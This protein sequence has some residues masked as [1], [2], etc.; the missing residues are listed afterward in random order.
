MITPILDNEKHLFFNVK[1]SFYDTERNLIS[2]DDFKKRLSNNELVGV[3]KTEIKLLYNDDK[4]KLRLVIFNQYK[5]F[6]KVKNLNRVVPKKYKS[7]V[8]FTINL[9]T[10][11]IYTY[12]INH[13]MKNRTASKTIRCNVFYT[14]TQTRL[15][16]LLGHY[17]TYH[18]E[19]VPLL[20]KLLNLKVDDYITG[21]DLLS[22]YYL[23]NKNIKYDYVDNLK[24]FIGLLRSSKKNYSNKHMYAI[25][26]EILNIED[27]RYVELFYT[28]KTFNGMYYHMVLFDKFKLDDSQI[29]IKNN[30]K[31]Y[32]TPIPYEFIKQIEFF[33]GK[34]KPHYKFSYRDFRSANDILH[35][36]R[37]LYH[38]YCFDTKI[39][40]EDLSSMSKIKR[41]LEII[42][43]H[44]T[45]SVISDGFVEH[46]VNSIDFIEKKLGKGYDVNHQMLPKYY[47]E[48]LVNQY[49]SNHNIFNYLYVEF[50]AQRE[51]GKLRVIF[52]DLSNMLI[53]Y[54]DQHILR[55]EVGKSKFKKMLNSLC[56]DFEKYQNLFSAKFRFSHDKLVTLCKEDNLNPIKYISKI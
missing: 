47:G 32:D 44:M 41:I 35:I 22:A 39:N 28:Y 2:A 17:F 7:H 36:L 6:V 37:V 4:T 43:F 23:N 31:N 29:F 19:L 30:F 1:E 16:S 54:K 24:H 5:R 38:F 21:S 51:D 14:H 53:R 52:V 26:Q 42:M 25:T 33:I 13:N 48:M 8:G 27:P 46:N 50:I 55:D 34:L 20:C 45:S 9:V 11:N 15:D 12:N 49:I 3:E 18:K 40:V 56:Y 10:K